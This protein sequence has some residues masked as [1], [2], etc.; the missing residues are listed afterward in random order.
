[1]VDE[2]GVYR[3]WNRSSDFVVLFYLYM[4]LNVVKGGC[5]IFNEEIGKKSYIKNCG[6]YLVYGKKL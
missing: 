3:V 6:Y 5:Y 4:L 1:M 2:F